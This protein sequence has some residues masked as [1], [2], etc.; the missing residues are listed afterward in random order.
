MQ[1]Q[2]ITLMKNRRSIYNIGR[3]IS[4]SQDEISELVKEA[5]RESPS[6]FNSQTARA[7]VLFGASHN[8]LWDI[9]AT[10]LRKEVPTEEAFQSTKAKL[11]TFRAGYGTVL[12][13]E[14]QD[15][16]KDLQEQ[17]ALYAEN[18]PI[19]SEQGS[20]I[21][22]MSVWVAFAENS[23]GASLQHYN[24]LIDADVAA[25]WHLPESWK[26]RGQMPFGSIES[27]AGEKEYMDDEA[28]FRV[29]N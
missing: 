22:S 10:S 15:V 5:V 20:G 29:F 14:D 1:K 2:V 27:D 3:N 28:R 12:F 18:F 17:F 8:R 25:E 19:W 16:V 6:S 24:P 11:D 13:F 26:L 4:L 21:A 7:V 23:I 9:T